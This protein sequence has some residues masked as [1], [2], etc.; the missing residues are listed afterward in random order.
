MEYGPL[1][2]DLNLRVRVHELEKALGEK[3]CFSLGPLSHSSEYITAFSI[4]SD[5]VSKSNINVL[6]SN[7]YNAILPS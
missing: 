4:F 5:M 6:W 3:V 1:K 2:I 7:S